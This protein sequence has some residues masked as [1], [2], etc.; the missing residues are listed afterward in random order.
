MEKNS[1]FAAF[2]PEAL[3][4]CEEESKVVSC[5]NLFEYIEFSVHCFFS[6][7]LEVFMCLNISISGVMCPSVSVLGTVRSFRLECLGE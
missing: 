6:V 7:F 5:I 4:S 2:F 1:V 3:L